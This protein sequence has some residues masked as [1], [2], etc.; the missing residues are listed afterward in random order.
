M[1]APQSDIPDKPDI[2]R[3]TW[4]ALET[5]GAAR[6]PGVKGRIPNFV[7]AEAA[8]DLLAETDEWKRA[9]TIKANPDSPQFPVRKRALLE[10]KTVYMA[11]PKLA[12]STPFVML[13]PDLLDASPHHAASIKGSSRFGVPVTVDEM[14][15]IDLIVCGTV[16]ANRE[17]VRVGKGGGYS[18]LEFALGVEHGFVSPGTVIATT[19]HP[20]QMYDGPLPET[21]HDFSLDLIVT[22]FDVVRPA[23]RS[24]PPGIVWEDLDADKI[25]AIPALGA[26]RKRQD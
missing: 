7:G 3:A 5:S 11:V 6:F 17:G 14:P 25:D 8:A 15:S 9:R 20:I 16:A 1:S 24:R 26:L 10:G 21:G 23:P 13:D 19:L 2:R 18:D 12:S 4:D 22:P